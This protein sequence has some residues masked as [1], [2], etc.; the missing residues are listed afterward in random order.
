MDFFAQLKKQANNRWLDA[1]RQAGKV[2]DQFL[3]P[4]EAGHSRQGESR[5]MLLVAVSPRT[6]ITYALVT[7]AAQLAKCDISLRFIFCDVEDHIATKAFIEAMGKIVVSETGAVLGRWATNPCLADA[8]EQ[9]ILGTEMSLTG[10]TLRRGTAGSNAIYIVDH[11]AAGSVR[12]AR[13]TYEELW[14]VSRPMSHH[15]AGIAESSALLGEVGK[16]VFSEQL[17]NKL[18]PVH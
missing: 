1:V 15:G 18:N 10:D 2:I 5:S 6:P 16:T 9:L 17:E 8:N 11:D 13:L 14:R 7:R 3:A 12:Y 4:L